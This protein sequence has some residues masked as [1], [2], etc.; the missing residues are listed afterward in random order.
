[1]PAKLRAIHVGGGVQVDSIQSDVHVLGGW[2]NRNF[3]GGLRSFTFE[4]KP[5]VVLYPTRIPTL[6][7]PDRLLPE[8]RANAQFR[9]PGFL[10]ARTGLFARLDGSIA[11]VILAAGQSA[12]Q[13]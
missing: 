4:M 3:F 5:G 9:Q 6:E 8:G 10:E 2:E 1:E 12:G 11:P 13:I 7:K